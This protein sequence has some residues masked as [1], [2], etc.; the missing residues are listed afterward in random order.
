MFFESLR[1]INDNTWLQ[2]QLVYFVGQSY[3]DSNLAPLIKGESME[4][5]D[6][7]LFFSVLHVPFFTNAVQTMLKQAIIMWAENMGLNCHGLLWT[8][9]A[10][11][12]KIFDSY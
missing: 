2:L 12:A 3:E 9:M 4:T 1:S 10:V 11:A 6:K 5:S 8:E 7:Y